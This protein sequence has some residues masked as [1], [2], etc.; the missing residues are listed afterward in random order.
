MAL[1]AY[2]SLGSAVV[3]RVQDVRNVPCLD[4][5]KCAE[6]GPVKGHSGRAWAGWIGRTP[7]IGEETLGRMQKLC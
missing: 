6:G 3:V 5:E 2:G 1:M 4:V 7:R